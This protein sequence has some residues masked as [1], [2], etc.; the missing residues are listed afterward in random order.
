MP[1]NAPVLNQCG[2]LVGYTK[3]YNPKNFIATEVYNIHDEKIRADINKD[4][5]LFQP[6]SPPPIDPRPSERLLQALCTHSLVS[7]GHDPLVGFPSL[8]KII[9]LTFPKI[10]PLQG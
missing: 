6:R 1:L 7:E 9:V 2:A 10:F 3:S 4:A 8:G 5:I